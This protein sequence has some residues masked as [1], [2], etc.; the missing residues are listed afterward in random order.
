M[1]MYRKLYIYLTSQ[2][3]EALFF[4]DAKDPRRAEHA[5]KILKNALEEVETYISGEEK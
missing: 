3:D 2:I 4:L 5:R 1:D